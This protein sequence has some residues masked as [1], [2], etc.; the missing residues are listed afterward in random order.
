MGRVL[1]LL[2]RSRDIDPTL[3]TRAA[4]V[5]REHATLHEALFERATRLEGRAG[6][7]EVEG[8]PS[9]SARNRAERAREEI[10]GSL[11]A[12]R[13]S[14]AASTGEEGRRAFDEELARR[15]PEV[16]LSDSSAS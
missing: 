9:E 1:D 14:F 7:L 12:L 6:R 16:A 10:S 13:E 15:Y 4:E 5:I 11:A 3:R 2:G 8:T